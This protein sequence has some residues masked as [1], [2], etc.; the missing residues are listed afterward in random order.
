MEPII[1]NSMKK[2][3]PT[4]TDI[5]RLANVSQATVSMILNKKYNV[6]FSK[7]TIERV[8]EAAKELGYTMKKRQTRK[9]W[10]KKLIVAFCPTLTNP[11]YVMLLQ[12]IEEVAKD[13]GY[14]VFVCNTLRDLRTEEDFLKM[15]S[16]I[17]PSGIIYTCNPSACFKEEILS[18]AENFPFVVIKNRDFDME[19]DAVELN[20]SKPG[21]IMAQ[22]LLALGHRKVGFISPPLTRR[23]QQRFQR[24]EG[25]IQE[26]REAGLGDQV[27]VKAAGE[28][29]DD[30]VPGMDSEYKIG[31]QLTREL[32][33]E[34]PDLTAIAG[35]NDMIALGILDAL[36]EAKVKVP[37]EI[38]VIGC[39]NILYGKL[40][41]IA[42]T[43]I[44]HFVQQKGRDASEIILK[45]INSSQKREDEMIPTS[46]Y[47]IE[48]EPRLIIRGTTAIAR[49]K[50]ND[51]K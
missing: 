25:F 16:A 15:M 41:N 31:Y 46:I 7:A 26:F 27:Y 10:G 3:K 36:N 44:E 19:V 23:Q 17:Q 43:T 8:E 39:D 21:R 40:K 34:H 48:Y 24:V 28:E 6:S 38:S 37:S 4:T 42:L 29:V 18:L 2:K 20:N 50:K 33:K 30:E 13:N 35:L 47:H 51:N 1:I 9:T 32:L 12:G 11:Y 45:K 5:A 22:H 49:V 14:A